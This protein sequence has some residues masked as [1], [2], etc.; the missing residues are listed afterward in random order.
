MVFN[1]Q[2]DLNRHSLGQRLGYHNKKQNG[3]QTKRLV[4]V[5]FMVIEEGFEPS[6]HSLEG[7][8]SIQLSYPTILKLSAK[9]I[10]F[11]RSHLK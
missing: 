6:T 2:Q 10:L 1:G 11:L 9:V 3:D 8:C 4:P 5:P 7:C